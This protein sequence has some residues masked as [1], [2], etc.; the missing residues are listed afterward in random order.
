LRARIHPV[1]AH[2]IDE[3]RAIESIP[4]FYQIIQSNLRRPLKGAEYL[5]Q[6]FKMNDDYYCSIF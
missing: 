5:T 1:D 4:I 3:H 6:E 2:R